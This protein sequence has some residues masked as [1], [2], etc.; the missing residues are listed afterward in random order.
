[1][2]EITL[3]LIDRPHLETTEVIVKKGVYGHV[4]YF[5]IL[6]TFKDHLM[7]KSKYSTWLPSSQKDFF[8]T[9]RG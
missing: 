1:M 2:T 7:V 3:R 8:G 5:W 9:L 4:A 6:W